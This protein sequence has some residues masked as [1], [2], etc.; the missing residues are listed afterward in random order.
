MQNIYTHTGTV[1]IPGWLKH[2][3]KGE[4]AAVIELNCCKLTERMVEMGGQ[5]IDLITQRVPWGIVWMDKQLRLWHPTWLKDIREIP[6][7]P[8]RGEYAQDY[9]D[10]RR[11]VGARPEESLMDAPTSLQGVGVFRDE[12][13]QIKKRCGVPANKGWAS[14]CYILGQFNGDKRKID[15]LVNSLKLLHNQIKSMADF[16]KAIAHEVIKNTS[17]EFWNLSW[18][19]AK[20]NERLRT[21]QCVSGTGT[22]L[23]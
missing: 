15:E 3:I 8:V 1:H 22:A 16:E 14:A 19:N 7:A 6:L 11:Y 9:L 10:A 12:W 18:D 17:P 5:A 13:E 21:V 20:E 2:A 4:P 23:L